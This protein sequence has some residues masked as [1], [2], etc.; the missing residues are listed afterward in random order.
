MDSVCLLLIGYVRIS[1]IIL[2][3]YWM[4]TDP[5]KA[6]L[7]FTLSHAVLDDLD[8]IAARRFNQGGLFKHATF[9]ELYT[10]DVILFSI[11][12]WFGGVFD[13]VID[14]LVNRKR[15]QYNIQGLPHMKI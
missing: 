15:P 9:R 1:L 10:D 14:R 5:L 13:I 7:C 12:T 3:C 11:A 6:A 8:G 2:T 4:F